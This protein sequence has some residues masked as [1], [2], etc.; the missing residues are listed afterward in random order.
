MEGPPRASHPFFLAA[1]AAAI[2]LS[3]R[4]VR[5]CRAW[6]LLLWCF[7]VSVKVTRVCNQVLVTNSPSLGRWLPSAG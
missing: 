4:E 3:C 1:A 6:R 7:I 5:G 2:S